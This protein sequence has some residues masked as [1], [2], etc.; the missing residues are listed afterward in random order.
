MRLFLLLRCAHSFVHCTTNVVMTR[1]WLYVLSSLAL[2]F[3]L[4]HALVDRFR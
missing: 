2:W 3:M 4:G 1:F